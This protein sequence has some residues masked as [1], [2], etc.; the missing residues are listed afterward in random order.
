MDSRTDFSKQVMKLIAAIPKGKVATYGQIAK[1]AGKPHGA[2]GVGWLLHSSTRSR[3]L[4]WQRVIKAGGHLPF[5]EWSSA[6]S[7]QKRLLE[8]EGVILNNRR[9]DLKKYLWNKVEC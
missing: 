4:P 1:L 3:K 5:P 7:L 6:W 8:K 9:I 2:R